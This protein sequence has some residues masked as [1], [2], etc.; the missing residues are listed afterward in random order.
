M[1]RKAPFAVV[2]MMLTMC[3]V[4]SAQTNLQ[5]GTGAGTVNAVP[6][7]TDPNLV[8][9]GADFSI[10]NVNGSNVSGSQILLVFGIP[11]NFS[12]S[13]TSNPLGAITLYNP[14]SGS[15]TGGVTAGISS[16]FATPTN[17]SSFGIESATYF[18]D[19]F[20][21]NFPGITLAST[22]GGLLNVGIDSSNNFA[23][24]NAFDA[25]LSVPAL[26]N[27]QQFGIYAFLIDL[28]G[29]GVGANGLLDVTVP[30]GLPQGTILSAVSS[31]G[32]TNT[33]ANAGGVTGLVVTPEP[34][35]ALL[36][37][38]GLLGCAFLLQRRLAAAV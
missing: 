34:D 7:G 17:A 23:N 26:S 21:G 8:G 2:M 11:N 4:V 38:T 3:S 22:I 20:Y 30:G 24:W 37:F 25:S 35:S 13:Y 29:S 36:L 5:F 18:A 15:A 33:W 19:G 10:Y 32:L 6:P 28:P 14:Y 1:I 31:D 16:S 12:N 27:V 9:T